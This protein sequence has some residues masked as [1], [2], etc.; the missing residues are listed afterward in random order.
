MHV[1][2][3]ARQMR[4]NHIHIAQ[5]LADLLET[6]CNML[7]GVVLVAKRYLWSDSEVA[8]S[9]I[10]GKEE[11]GKQWVRSRVRKIKEKSKLYLRCSFKRPSHFNLF[12]SCWAFFLRRHALDAN[13]FFS[14]RLLH[15][16]PNG[17]SLTGVISLITRLSC[18]NS[19]PIAANLRG[20]AVRSFPSPRLAFPLVID[21]FCN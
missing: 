9:Q 18:S 20:L 10:K 8:L 6:V 21:K 13:L 11:T 4:T 14:L 16:A 17:I 3:H 7:K 1:A 19:F 2:K 12:A 5:L 15:L